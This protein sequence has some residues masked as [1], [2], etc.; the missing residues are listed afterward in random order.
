MKKLMLLLITIIMMPSCSN[1]LDV[2]SQSIVDK[3]ELFK[4]PEGF[5]AA[6][7]GVYSRCTQSNLYGG[8]LTF[9]FPDVLAQNYTTSTGNPY[10]QTADYNYKD[11]FL[12]NKKDSVWSGLYSAISDCNLILENIEERKNVLTEDLSN[13]IQGEALGLRAYLHLDAFRLF[14]QSMITDASAKNI[15]YVKSFSAEATP[16]STGTEVLTLVI[17]DLEQSIQLLAV[18]DPIFISDYRVGYPTGSSG[19]SNEEESANVF[20]RN[21]RHRM[22]Y[23]AVC[24]T[25]ARAYLCNGDKSQALVYAEKVIN[26]TK[27]PWTATEDFTADADENKDRI[28]YKELIFGWFI[29]T[30]EHALEL[31][32]RFEQGLGNDGQYASADLGN[33]IYEVAGPGAED[34]RYK[35]WFKDI[36]V[37]SEVMALQKYIHPMNK[38]NKHYLMAPAIRLSEMY[39][40]A[41]ECIYADNPV[42]AWN[43]FNQV[44]NHRGITSQVQDTSSEDAFLNELVKECRK[45]FYGEGQL[46]YMYKRLNRN[47]SGQDGNEISADSRI[48]VLPLPQNEIDFRQ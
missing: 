13:L 24:A 32:A 5:M 10:Q 29:N 21:R 23:Y 39:Y 8:E 22:N 9:G 25:L 2:K 12:V 38:P 6:L 14:G 20:L 11:P 15:P 40:I 27:F 16:L 37:G 26:S 41:A 17:E 18:S 28:L 35:E 4:T 34:L 19:E 44:R 31:S 30:E 48:F 7:N 33:S 42:A 46:F 36:N 43:Y 3:D 1:F 45:E 47:V